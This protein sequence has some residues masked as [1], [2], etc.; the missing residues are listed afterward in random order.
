MVKV[1]YESNKQTLSALFF[2]IFSAI[3]TG[4]IGTFTEVLAKLEESSKNLPLEA[5]RIPF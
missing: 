5:F 1:P 2:W 4:G 3:I